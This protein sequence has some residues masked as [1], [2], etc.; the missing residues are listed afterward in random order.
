[1]RKN[2]RTFLKSLIEKV[3]PLMFKNPDG[4]SFIYQSRRDVYKYVLW[5]LHTNSAINYID[6]TFILFRLYNKRPR[7]IA[8]IISRYFKPLDIKEHVILE[9]DFVKN[10]GFYRDFIRALHA[11]CD[12]SFDVSQFDI[13][14]NE[15]N[16]ELEYKQT[17]IKTKEDKENEQNK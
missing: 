4:T 1:M 16:S 12:T 10:K 15:F 17:K 2:E 7:D 6:V 9:S 14:F 5:F 8:Y 3:N 11:M 13:A